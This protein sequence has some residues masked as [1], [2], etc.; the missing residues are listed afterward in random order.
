[1]TSNV[2]GAGTYEASDQRTY[3]DSEKND[4]E[5]FK[6]GK[7]NSHKANDS[8]KPQTMFI[9]R[10]SATANAVPQRMSAR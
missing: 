2:G 10:Q 8:S 5:R 3:K 6:E 4:A 7:E 1:M 9:L